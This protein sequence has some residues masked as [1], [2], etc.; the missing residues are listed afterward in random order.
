MGGNA[1]TLPCTVS[2]NGLGIKASSLIDTGANGYT[3][4]DAEF[5]KTIAHF[6]GVEPL[7]LKSPCKVRG[8]DGVQTTPITH[9]LE[10]ALL[11][12]GRRVQV[13]MLV[14]NLGDHDI[15]LGHKWFV[16]MGVL[17]DCKNRKLIWPDDRPPTKGW[18]RILTITKE[19][20]RSGSA[21]PQHQRN[22]DQRDKL[23]AMDGP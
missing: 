4:I 12:D 15:I 23:M 1:F 11:M 17:I 13:P 8:F 19:M 6:L 5:A 21:R 16:R 9:S 22:A 3:F 14:V 18:S 7:P 10:L 2:N 20:L